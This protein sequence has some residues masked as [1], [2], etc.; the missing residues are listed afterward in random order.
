MFLVPSILWKYKVFFFLFFSQCMS[1][2]LYKQL[3]WEKL[4]GLCLL[5]FFSKMILQRMVDKI[6]ALKDVHV[7]IHGTCEYVTYMEKGTLQIW[8]RLRTLRW[9]IILDYFSG[10]NF[11]TWVLKSGEPFPTGVR[12]NMRI[13]EGTERCY[14]AGNEDQWRGHKP[15]NAGSSRT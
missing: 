5:T 11:I 4:R 13:E 1:L 14:V 2:I 10:P 12:E 6:I 3:W 7:L 8:L 15:R 9:E